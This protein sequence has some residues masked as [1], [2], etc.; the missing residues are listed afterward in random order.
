MCGDMYLYVCVYVG[1]CIC[2]YCIS[3]FFPL[4]ETRSNKNLAAMAIAAHIS[5]FLNSILLKRNKG[6]F[7]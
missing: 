6:S 7:R 2:M 5:W 4:R 3:Q 1:I